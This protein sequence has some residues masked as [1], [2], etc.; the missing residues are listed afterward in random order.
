MN[1]WSSVLG[2]VGGMKMSGGG[3]TQEGHV[4]LME[5]DATWSGGLSSRQG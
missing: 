2:R 4:L 5:G 3:D 1:S